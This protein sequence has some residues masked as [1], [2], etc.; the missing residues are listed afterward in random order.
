MEAVQSY[1]PSQAFCSSCLRLRL[2]FSASIAARSAASFVATM[3]ARLY[4]SSALTD[5]C[6]LTHFFSSIESSRINCFALARSWCWNGGLKPVMRGSSSGIL[7]ENPAPSALYVSLVR[8][9]RRSFNARFEDKGA[10][11]GHDRV[12]LFS[13]P[14]IGQLPLSLVVSASPCYCALLDAHLLQQVERLSVSF[15]RLAEVS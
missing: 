1:S 3:S 5:L 9:Q 8:S 7:T 13:F 2:S 12:D 6:W 10:R 11:I 14:L 4:V 15:G